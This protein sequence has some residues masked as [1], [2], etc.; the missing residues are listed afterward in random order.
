MKAQRI[1]LANL[2]SLLLACLLLSTCGDDTGSLTEVE[3][4]T[5]LLTNGTWSLSSVS[6]DDAEAADLFEDFS[7]DFTE[8]DY[9]TTGTTPVWPR[10]GVWSFVDT[11]SPTQF[12][13]DDEIVVTIISLEKKMLTL[14][15]IWTKQIISGGRTTAIKGKHVFV[16]QR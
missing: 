13:R 3:R 12:E 16:L 1:N 11:N 10:N 8:T 7:V 6:V 4:V 5:K 9:T 2:V 15:L 14:E